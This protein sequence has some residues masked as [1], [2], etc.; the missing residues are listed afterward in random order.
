MI[1]NYAKSRDETEIE[2]IRKLFPNYD[3]T[4]LEAEY[5][6][7]GEIIKITTSEKTLQTIMK[8]EGFTES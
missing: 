8:G 5:S 4:K 2:H 6:I 1:K 7:N 3:K